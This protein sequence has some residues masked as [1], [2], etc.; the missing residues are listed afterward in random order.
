[1]HHATFKPANE[2]MASVQVINPVIHQQLWVPFGGGPITWTIWTMV[3]APKSDL[4]L[5]GPVH[6]TCWFNQ[7][8]RYEVQLTTV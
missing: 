3:S 6:S 5:E 2:K 8:V 1:V 4:R 7:L